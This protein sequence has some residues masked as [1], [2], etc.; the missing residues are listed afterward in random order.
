MI[1]RTLYWWVAPAIAAFTSLFYAGPLGLAASLVGIVGTAGYIGGTWAIIR[2]IGG[3]GRGNRYNR[4]G[5]IALVALV[6]IKLPLIAGAMVLARRLGPSGPACFLAGL[7]S[8][9]CALS[10]WAILDARVR[11]R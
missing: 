4:S 9:Y 7:L 1:G 10:W 2:L 3:S 11:N 5:T 8:V 6:M